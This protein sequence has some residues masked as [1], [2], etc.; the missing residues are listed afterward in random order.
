MISQKFRTPPWHPSEHLKIMDWLRFVIAAL[1]VAVGS[2]RK[3]PS[4]HIAAAFR[5]VKCAISSP[6][7]AEHGFVPKKPQVLRSMISTFTPWNSFR[8]PLHPAGR[9]LRSAKS[10]LRQNPP[11]PFRKIRHLFAYPRKANGFVPQNAPIHRKEN[12]R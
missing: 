8:N 9:W 2:L 1:P 7:H 12:P 5:F 10:A 6:T 4:F 3:P 11:I